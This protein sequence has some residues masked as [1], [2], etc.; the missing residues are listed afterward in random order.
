MHHV[1]NSGT[2]ILLDMAKTL[3]YGKSKEYTNNEYDKYPHPNEPFYVHVA[4][5]YQ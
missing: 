1:C 4:D 5:K 2:K 3:K